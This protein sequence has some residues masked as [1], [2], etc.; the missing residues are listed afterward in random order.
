MNEETQSTPEAPSPSKVY[1]PT[2]SVG[3][4]QL[5]TGKIVKIT[6]NVAFVDYGAR[7]EGYIEL[8]EL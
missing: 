1:T 8:S 5:V 3:V 2:A 4:G 7:N 6:G